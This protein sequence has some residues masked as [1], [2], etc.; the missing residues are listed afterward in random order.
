M[1]ARRTGII[2]NDAQWKV[3]LASMVPRMRRQAN[4]ALKVRAEAA[5]AQAQANVHV[6]TGRLQASGRVEE[7]HTDGEDVYE[8]VF[9]GE[10]YDIVYAGYEEELHP[11][12]VPAAMA[13]FSEFDAIEGDVL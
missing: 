4:D 5:L 10:E 7:V 13:A 3:G 2:V 1:A 6:R 11:Y 8:V 12:L 9:G